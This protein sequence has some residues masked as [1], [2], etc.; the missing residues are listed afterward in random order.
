MQYLSELVALENEWHNIGI[1][2]EEYIKAVNENP[3]MIENK[4]R[5]LLIYRDKLLSSNLANE[6]KERRL[7]EIRKNLGYLEMLV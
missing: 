4:K 5:Q 2:G 3:E 1:S 7:K 6:D